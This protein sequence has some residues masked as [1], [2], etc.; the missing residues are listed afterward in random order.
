MSN[1]L[2]NYNTCAD[3]IYIG[4]DEQVNLLLRNHNFA[5]GVNIPV[6]ISYKIIINP[7][8]EQRYQGDFWGNE[9]Y[10]I[11]NTIEYA[12]KMLSK[13]TGSELGGAYSDNGTKF[14]QDNRYIPEFIVGFQNRDAYQLYECNYLDS[15]AQIGYQLEVKLENIKR[16]LRDYGEDQ[17]R[18]NIFLDDVYIDSNIKDELAQFKWLESVQS[19]FDL[20]RPYPD[21]PSYELDLVNKQPNIEIQAEQMDKLN[22]IIDHVLHS[23]DRVANIKFTPVS[24]DAT[25]EFKFK[26]K[27]GQ[28]KDINQHKDGD[29]RCDDAGIREGGA[30]SFHYAKGKTIHVEYSGTYC[31]SDHSL[32]ELTWKDIF[33]ELSHSFI[34][35]PNDS[36]FALEYN[37]NDDKMYNRSIS[38][39]YRAD[40]GCMSV[41]AFNECIYQ[42]KSL[43]PISYLPIDILALQ[44]MYSANKAT[45]AS[46]TRYIFSDNQVY[47]NDMNNPMFPMDLPVSSIYSLYDAGGVNT[48]DLTAVTKAIIIDLEEGAGH[49]NEIGNGV[50]IIDY[51]TK[52]HNVIIGS[53]NASVRLHPNESN[54]IFIPSKG[55]HITLSNIGPN[56]SI[57]LSKEANQNIITIDG[58]GCTH[59]Y[60]ESGDLETKVCIPA[61]SYI[62]V[63]VDY[64]D[65]S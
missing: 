48:L 6:D 18:V 24:G 14:I 56:D 59:P 41:M 47:I 62:G 34:D 39:E 8:V 5:A 16:K 9:G 27:V 52:I 21:Y 44:H 54:K 3:Q 7:T 23:A 58:Y 61:G 1:A 20:K 51:N 29:F 49:F 63:I 36:V 53:A 31:A 15:D 55:A 43:Q 10:A 33:H 19:V 64:F 32:S 11:H 50:F 12:S 37:L 42:G 40:S 26:V 38:A 35:H 22:I 45:E 46:D 28:N 17:S 4:K 25:L 13:I 2:D 60:S 57:L 30:E 65:F